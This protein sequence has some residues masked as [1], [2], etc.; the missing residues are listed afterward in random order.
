MPNKEEVIEPADAAV[1]FCGVR[2]LVMM[3]WR[4][5]LDLLLVMMSSLDLLIFYFSFLRKGIDGW[6]VAI[7]DYK[8]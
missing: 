4:Q 2:T 7:V 6:L 3:E 8:P 1:H 5:S